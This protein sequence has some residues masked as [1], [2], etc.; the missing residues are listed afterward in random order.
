MYVCIQFLWMATRIHSDVCIL[1][2]HLMLTRS[3]MNSGERDV[4]ARIIIPT[5]GQ[6]NTTPT[7]W[8][9]GRRHHRHLSSIAKQRFLCVEKRI[10]E[11]DDLFHN[12][13]CERA[14]DNESLSLRSS[15]H[16]VGRR[17]AFE[18]LVVPKYALFALFIVC[19]VCRTGWSGCVYGIINIL[20]LV[21]HSGQW[22]WASTMFLFLLVFEWV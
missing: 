20:A 5:Q 9:A 6:R 18:Y 2:E 12:E 11:R 19:F 22:M 10:R 16:T 21:I 7:K 4:V 14:I 15:T 8:T 13:L 1:D 3:M 17:M